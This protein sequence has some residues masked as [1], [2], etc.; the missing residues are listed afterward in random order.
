MV[1][2]LPQLAHIEQLCD[3][4]I[5]TK[6]RHAPFPKQAKYRVEK[7]LEFVHDDLCG[8][9]MPATQGGRRYILLLVD[10]ATR[11][12]WAA[13][14]AEKSTTLESIK[15]IQVAAEN[16]CGRKLKV[17]RTDNSGEFTSASF[18]EYFAG[19]GVERHHSCDSS[20][21]CKLD[22]YFVSVK[23]IFC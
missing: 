1:R 11:Y 14:L 7:P 22:K 3:V 21:V 16:K 4:Y 17:F 5:T 15:K 12:M 6:H 2:G 10:D 13:F 8:P 20:C 18:A 23:Y 19:Q 9:M